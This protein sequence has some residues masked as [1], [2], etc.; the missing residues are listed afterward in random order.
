MLE[1]LA[2]PAA[3]SPQ[4]RGIVTDRLRTTTLQ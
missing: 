2:S 4:T 1:L 3:L